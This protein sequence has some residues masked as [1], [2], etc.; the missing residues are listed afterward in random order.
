MHPVPTPEM[1]WRHH[2]A[3][4]GALIPDPQLWVLGRPGSG[5]GA[6][7]KR[8]VAASRSRPVVVIDPSDGYEVVQDQLARRGLLDVSKDVEGVINP[9]RVDHAQSGSPRVPAGE[10]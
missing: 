1:W 10:W 9:P 8:L 2:H 3:V 6:L 4:G 7:A 5:K